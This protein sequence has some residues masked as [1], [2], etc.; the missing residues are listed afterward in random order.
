VPF[1]SPH[2]Q[3][4]RAGACP[5]SHAGT[6]GRIIHFTI[7]EI[8]NPLI[9]GYQDDRPPKLTDC[10]TPEL[11]KQRQGVCMCV[12]LCVCLSV[13]SPTKVCVCSP[14][15][16]C[17]GAGRP[18]KCVHSR[19]HRTSR[20]II[21]SVNH[22]RSTAV[23]GRPTDRPTV[24]LIRLTGLARS[25]TRTRGVSREIETQPSNC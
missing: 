24:G 3:P 2:R 4:R 8:M 18:I 22:A 25:R 6:D 17:E 10:C 11:L 14:V 20:F 16:P 12:A 9:D 21:A 7:G 15:R 13:R 23:S 5:T 19:R 1:I